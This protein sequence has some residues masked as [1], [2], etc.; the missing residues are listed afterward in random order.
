MGIKAVLTSLDGVDD[1]IKGL[2]K[3]EGDKFHLDLEA[4]DEH[5]SV[6]ALKRAKDH[7][8]EARQRA[9]N[10]LREA[11]TAAEKA[12]ETHRE[13]LK[14]VIPKAQSDA[15]EQSYKTK[16][17]TQKQEHEKAMGTKDAQINTLLVTSK[18]QALCSKISTAPDLL[19]PHVLKRLRAEEVDGTLLLVI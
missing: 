19:L 2:Y 13:T 16:L 1:S 12:E 8:K 9:E 18:A 5:P 15:L 11:R 6:G 10:E 3:Q 17:E 14:S 4:V 7:E